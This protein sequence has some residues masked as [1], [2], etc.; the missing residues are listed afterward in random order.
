VILGF[1][2]SAS[3]LTRQVLYSLSYTFSPWNAIKKGILR[4]QKKDLLEMD[5]RNF[6]KSID[7]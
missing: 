7:D 4:D 5:R 6:S 3:P 2:L 1:E